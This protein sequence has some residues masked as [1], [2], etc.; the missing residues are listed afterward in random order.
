MGHLDGED[1]NK[2]ALYLIKN[3]KDEKKPKVLKFYFEGLLKN[4]S[5]YD[6]IQLISSQT[7][8]DTELLLLNQIIRQKI[9]KEKSNDS[10]WTKYLKVKDWS[11]TSVMYDMDNGDNYFFF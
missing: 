4:K 6:A 2:L 10:I 7:S 8:D 9:V 1:F 5:N 11:E 3:V